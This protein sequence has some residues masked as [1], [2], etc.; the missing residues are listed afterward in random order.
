MATDPKEYLQFDIGSIDALIKSKLTPEF[1]DVAR[2]GSSAAILSEAVASTFSLLL[3]Q[4]NRTASNSSFTKTNSLE[5]L[6]N[7]TKILG[8]NPIGHHASS[9]FVDISVNTILSNGSYTIP[10]YT[11][12]ETPQGKFST[13]S[14]LTFTNDSQ[15]T[16]RVIFNDIVMKG[17]PYVEHDL[18]LSDGSS[19]QK[20]L[21]SIGDNQVDH[22]DIDIYVKEPNGMWVQFS[23]VDSLF[24]STPDSTEFEVRYNEFGSYDIVFGDG[25]NGCLV[26][27]DAEI[28]IYYLSVSS[29]EGILDVGEVDTQPFRFNTN[30]INA[31]II[32]VADTTGSVFVN[33]VNTNFTFTNTSQSTP[34]DGPESLDDI[35]RNAP[36]TF[37][38]QNR[39]VTKEDYESFIRN[40]FSDFI[41]DVLILDNDEYMNSYIK[42]YSDLGLNKPY[43]ENRALF[44]QLKFSSAVNFNN[45]YVFVVPVIG[46]YLIDIQKRNIVDRLSKTKT[47]S[48]EITPSDPIYINF[49]VATPTNTIEF[50]DTTTS[51]II[52]TKTP[53]TTRSESDLLVDFQDA[54]VSYFTDRGKSFN[55][56]IDVSELTGILLSIDGIQHISTKNGTVTNTGLGL[57]EWNPFFP[58]RVTTAP[59]TNRFTGIFVPRF[60][61]NSIFDRIT[62][63]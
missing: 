46:D 49:A 63:V 2:G 48:A 52:I 54:L 50:S 58:E 57:Y 27:E 36:S 11:Y 21:L 44:N 33:D 56:I 34:K 59:P 12:I 29:S 16:E 43:E 41:S 6:I 45:V 7:Q 13:T 37:K 62:F 42:Y 9:V 25:I 23:R 5:S 39:L 4:L 18:I 40:N 14:D 35:R 38:S 19:N 53:N 3:Y 1:P 55:Q 30:R 32:D 10:R 31:I 17:G 28:A 26:P 22:E 8:Y 24:L 61:S 15:L 51:E 60:E 20:L 47:L